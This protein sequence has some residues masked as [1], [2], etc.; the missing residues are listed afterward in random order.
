MA[1]RNSSPSKL[2]QMLALDGAFFRISGNIIDLAAGVERCLN[3]R[4]VGAV[5]PAECSLQCLVG[6]ELGVDL[7]QAPCPGQNCDQC[8][9]QFIK[10]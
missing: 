7:T 8:V 4:L 9:E 5:F 3:D 10:G 6:P 2:A 1:V